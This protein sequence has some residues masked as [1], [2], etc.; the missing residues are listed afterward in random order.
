MQQKTSRHAYG[1]QT[2]LKRSSRIW[3]T[4][5]GCGYGVQSWRLWEKNEQT[6]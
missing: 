6:F 5:F 2:I 3:K 4:V 1:E